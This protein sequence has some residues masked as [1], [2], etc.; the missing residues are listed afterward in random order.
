[1][2]SGIRLKVLLFACLSFHPP[3]N[4]MAT[5]VPGSTASAPVDTTTTVLRNAR[6]VTMEDDRFKN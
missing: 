3:A 6:L 2:G 5:G 1:M 4:V